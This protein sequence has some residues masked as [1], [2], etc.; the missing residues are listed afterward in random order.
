MDIKDRTSVLLSDPNAISLYFTAMYDAAFPRLS[1]TPRNIVRFGTLFRIC[2]VQMESKR[3]KK[4]AT[5]SPSKHLV[6]RASSYHQNSHKKM[7]QKERT[8]I[9]SWGNHCVVLLFS[10]IGDAE[11]PRFSLKSRLIHVHV[12]ISIHIYTYR[13]IIR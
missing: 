4:M 11:M 5:F 12:H 1:I 6:K 9:I 3:S 7:E 10:L 8:F 13:G 2:L